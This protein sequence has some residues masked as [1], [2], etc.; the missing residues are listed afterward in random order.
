MIENEQQLQI[1]RA[2]VD[3]FALA[4]V[5]HQNASKNSNAHPRLIRAQE[6]AMRSE[7]EVLQALIAEFETRTSAQPLEGEL[8]R[9]R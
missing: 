9:V 4:I 3:R 5:E 8:P 1:T 7:L 2:Q 6:E